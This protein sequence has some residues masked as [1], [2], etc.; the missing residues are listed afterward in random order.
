MAKKKKK[1]A[2]DYDELLKAAKKR[3][4]EDKRGLFV[5]FPYDL[6][7]GLKEKCNDSSEDF[8]WTAFV[9]RTGNLCHVISPEGEMLV[10]LQFVDSINHLDL[11]QQ[12]EVLLR[13][14][15]DYIL[16]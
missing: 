16:M 4:G 14:I 8:M 12:H 3:I 13:R 9:N 5:V 11:F 6:R 10:R 15:G 7:A 2:L 1:E